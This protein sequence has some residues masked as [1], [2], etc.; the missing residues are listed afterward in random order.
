MD[1]ILNHDTLNYIFQFIHPSEHMILSETCKTFNEMIGKKTF[2]K[3]SLLFSRPE[4]IEWAIDHEYKIK[5][6]SMFRKAIKYGNTNVLQYLKDNIK[7]SNKYLI[8]SLF[9]HAMDKES[10][11]ILDWLMKSRCLYNN[12]ICNLASSSEIY[13]WIMTN[14]VWNSDQ[15]QNIIKSENIDKIMWVVKSVPLLSEYVCD[16]ASECNSMKVLKWA[17][18]NKFKYGET[19]C[20]NAALNGNLKMVKFLRKNKCKWSSWTIADAASNG[21]NHVIKWCL[22]NNCK[23]DEYACSEAFS[24]KHLDTLK[25]LIENKCPTDDKTYHDIL[26]K[27]E[28][29]N[30]V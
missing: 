3:D 21:H 23:V 17:I 24:N 26:H 25:L 5:K 11:D 29:L 14:L 16:I 28:D 27:K 4:L 30:T 19:T 7:N 12:V 18:K 15:L 6:W 9:I 20:S 2:P 22:K 10:I 1:Y 13:N 8:P